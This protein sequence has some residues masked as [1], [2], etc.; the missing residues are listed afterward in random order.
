MGSLTPQTL[1]GLIPRPLP[2]DPKTRALAEQVLKQGYVIIPNC[3]SRAEGKEAIAEIARLSG[4]D[5]KTSRDEFFGRKTSRIFALPNKTRLFDKFYILPQ[6]LAL[7]DYFLDPD[8]LMYVIQ[9][10]V[11]NPGEGQQPIHHDDGATR[12]PRPRAPLSAAIMVVLEDYTQTNGATKIIPASH[13]WGAEEKARKQDSISAVCPAGSVIYFLGTTYHSGGPNISDKPRHALTVQYCQ[14]Y[15]RPLENLMMCVDPRKLDE[16]PERVVDM[17]G[18]KSGFPFLGSGMLKEPNNIQSSKGL[19]YENSRRIES[20]K[21]NAEN[22][23]LVKKPSRLQH[24]D[25]CKGG[26]VQ[27]RWATEKS[28][29]CCV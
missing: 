3:F 26:R 2:S 19:I 6:V 9:S 16:I 28:T 5:P 1:A 25:I 18:Y 17:M 21:R 13:L 10:I 7:N 23:A 11:I 29:G 15:I 14:P 24:S 8:Y 20:A 4:K 27:G 22:G 12:L